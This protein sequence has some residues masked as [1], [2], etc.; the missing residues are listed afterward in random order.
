MH[1]FSIKKLNDGE[2][3]GIGGEEYMRLNVGTQRKV[4]EEAMLR[5]RRAVVGIGR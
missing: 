5:L 3:F 2:M 1:R 4:L